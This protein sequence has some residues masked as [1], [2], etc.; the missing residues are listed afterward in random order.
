MDTR[1]KS[2]HAVAAAMGGTEEKNDFSDVEDAKSSGVGNGNPRTIAEANTA[3]RG[4]FKGGE[5]YVSYY[6]AGPA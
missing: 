2:E 6:A 1:G 5:I 3:M 4:D